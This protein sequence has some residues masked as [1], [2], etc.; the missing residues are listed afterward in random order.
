MKRE[1]ENSVPNPFLN[2]K[3]NMAARPPLTTCPRE[4]FSSIPHP[5]PSGIGTQ[6][7]RNMRDVAA[8]TG[9]APPY[10]MRMLNA[11][12]G[13]PPF[14]SSSDLQMKRLCMKNA[15][16][17]Q[18]ELAP[19]N[20][21]KSNGTP[22]YRDNNEEIQKEVPI[23]STSELPTDTSVKRIWPVMG[24]G[25]LEIREKQSSYCF[26][27]DIP[28]VRKDCIDVSLKPASIVVECTRDPVPYAPDRYHHI[29]RPVGKLIRTIQLPSNANA[30]AISCS[31]VNG[32]LFINVGKKEVTEEVIK[33]IVN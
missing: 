2:P 14:L 17:P 3:T 22:V 8:I 32:V 28:G 21:P 7:I 29:E 26:E 24:F 15:P 11:R 27:L 1:R 12:A 10:I 13:L 23:L 19:F 4:F 18:A 33:V 5:L 25:K 31:Y 20:M 9:E 6:Y 16:T 30:D